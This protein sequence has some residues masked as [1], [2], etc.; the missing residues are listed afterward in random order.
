M[1]EMNRKDSNDLGDSD[2]KGKEEGEKVSLML[3]NPK[4][5]DSCTKSHL[6]EY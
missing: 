5:S 1:E 6:Q 4:D 2:S 3:L